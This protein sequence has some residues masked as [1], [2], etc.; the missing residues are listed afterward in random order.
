MTPEEMLS[1]MRRRST[2]TAAECEALAIQASPVRAGDRF[3]RPN[4]F[5]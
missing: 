3:R 5:W 4:Q 2:F 1:D